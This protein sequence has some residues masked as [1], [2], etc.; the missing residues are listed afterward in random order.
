MASSIPV[1]RGSGAG[2]GQARF[3][4]V[5]AAQEGRGN[6]LASTDYLAHSVWKVY[7]MREL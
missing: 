7:D 2:K 1:V 4:R 5:L 6:R 3:A